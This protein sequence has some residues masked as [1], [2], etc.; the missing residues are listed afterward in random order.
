M[1]RAIPWSSG[2][3]RNL[4]Q[5]KL[6]TVRFTHDQSCHSNSTLEAI[7]SDRPGYIYVLCSFGA[8]VLAL[9]RSCIGAAYHENAAHPLEIAPVEL[10][11][12][13]FSQRIDY[14]DHGALQCHVEIRRGAGS[15]VGSRRIWLGNQSMWKTSFTSCP[16]NAGLVAT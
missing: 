10:L 1:G 8:A 12:W 7:V 16:L 2:F 3:I 15:E 4:G 9:H 13:R 6:G 11:Y 14:C 5:G